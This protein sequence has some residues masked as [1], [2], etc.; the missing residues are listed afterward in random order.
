MAAVIAGPSRKISAIE[1]G[2]QKELEATR[3]ISAGGDSIFGERSLDH[4]TSDL[5]TLVHLVK[6]SLGAGILAMPLAF[7]N[8]GLS[9]GLVATF[10]IGFICTHCVHILVTTAHGLCRTHRIPSLTYG[11]VAEAAFL[12]GP[13]SLRKFCTV[14]GRTADTSVL[15]VWTSSHFPERGY[16]ALTAVFILVLCYIRNLRYLSPLSLLSNVLILG[17]LGICVYYFVQDLP[18]ASTRPDFSSWAQLP[19]FFSTAVFALEG[20]GVIMPLENNMKDPTNFTGCFRVLNTGMCVVISMYCA[21]GFYGYLKYGDIVKGS[22]TLNLPEGEVLAQASKLMVA[23]AV[24]FTYPLQMYVPVHMCWPG[25]TRRLGWNEI[26]WRGPFQPEHVFRFCCVL[27]T[28]CLALAIPELDALM[29]LIGAICLSAAG[30]I[31][32][33]VIQTVYRHDTLGPFKWILL[34]N[35]AIILFGLVGMVTGVY[36][37]ILQ[38]AR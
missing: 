15:D 10:F 11:G 37:S 16:I 5:D 34:K 7:K 33:A 12:N 19:N 1:R 30:I 18:P 2:Q 35:S 3:R 8:A 22:I 13:K 29:S 23:M 20:I 24:C 27:F 21:V 26:E 36:T 31:F 4:P 28:A 14:A 25:I 17:S 6:G 9:F 38:L 32:P